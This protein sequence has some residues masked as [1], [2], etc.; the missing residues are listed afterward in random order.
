MQELQSLTDILETRSLTELAMMHL[1]L[2]V[3]LY[4]TAG[5]VGLVKVGWLQGN[6]P[7]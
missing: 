2:Q 1:T 7:H 3:E 4:S 5:P 6:M